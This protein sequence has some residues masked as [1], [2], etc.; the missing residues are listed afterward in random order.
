MQI[1]QWAFTNRVIL[2][3]LESRQQMGVT[4]TKTYEN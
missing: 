4:K 2:P 3:E 1:S